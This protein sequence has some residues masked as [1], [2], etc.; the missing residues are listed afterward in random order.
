MQLAEA[1]KDSAGWL[2]TADGRHATLYAAASGASL[3]VSRVEATR[4]EKGLLFARTTRG[5]VYVLTLSDVFAGAIETP[6]S[7]SRK[8]GFNPV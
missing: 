2:V 8:A 7:E 6:R 3:N 1:T 5:E 4:V